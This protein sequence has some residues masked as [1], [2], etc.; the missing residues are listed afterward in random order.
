M[1]PSIAYYR[2]ERPNSGASPMRLSAQFMIF[3]AVA[4]IFSSQVLAQIRQGRDTANA[5]P[6]ALEETS[7]VA[8]SLG[9]QLLLPKDAKVTSDQRSGMIKYL[10][11]DGAS[12]EPTWTMNIQPLNSIQENPTAEAGASTGC[13][14]T[15][16]REAPQGRR[17][18][19]RGKGACFPGHSDQTASGQGRSR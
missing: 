11:S 13:K 4:S 5:D 14:A 16:G 19:H 10:I 1:G 6:Y 9:L 8:P 17:G 7:L 12:E 15:Q 3:A 2:Q 18:H